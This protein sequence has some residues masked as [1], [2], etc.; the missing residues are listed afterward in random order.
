M[1][2]IDASR[3]TYTHRVTEDAVRY[4]LA[5]E[6]AEAHGLITDGKMTKG[7]T[8]KVTFDGRRGGRGEYTIE[9]VFD[10][11]MAAQDALPKPETK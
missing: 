4:A 3:V 1:K 8:F 9:L 7:V 2:L 5:L 6:A 11:N 10:R